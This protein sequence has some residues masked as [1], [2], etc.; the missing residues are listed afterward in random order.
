MEDSTV[1]GSVVIVFSALGGS[2]M[3]GFGVD[4][5]STFSCF[6]GSSFG[7]LVMSIVT[8]ATSGVGV[9]AVG[10]SELVT[11]LTSRLRTF[12]CIPCSSSDA[13]RSMI[14]TCVF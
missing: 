8:G 14:G 2:A 1:A 11:E 13:S 3:R 9:E 5:C 6:V 12:D 10:C 7:C 4:V